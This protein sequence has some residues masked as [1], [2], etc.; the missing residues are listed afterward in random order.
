MIASLPSLELT[1]RRL[2]KKSTVSKEF[3]DARFKRWRAPPR[4]SITH[5]A[6]AKPARAESKIYDRDFGTTKEKENDYDDERKRED[7]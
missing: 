3:P 1:S 2:S 4:I 7:Q 6:S 5:W